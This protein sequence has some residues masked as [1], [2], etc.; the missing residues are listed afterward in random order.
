MA[1]GFEFRGSHGY[2]SPFKE[3][4]N[5]L[6]G[7]FTVDV[8]GVLHIDCLGRTNFV[9][10]LLASTLVPIGVFL[11][12]TGYQFLEDRSSTER[13]SV[14]SLSSSTSPSP[15]HA[16]ISSRRSRASNSTLVMKMA[17][18][19]RTFAQ[20]EFGSNPTTSCRRSIRAS[21]A[22]TQAHVA[23]NAHTHAAYTRAHTRATLTAI[24]HSL[25]QPRDPVYG[26][27]DRWRR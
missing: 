23:H 25:P 11:L 24:Y 17:T 14:T 12:E 2:P 20:S 7:I 4:M 21:H 1:S 5:S 3:V 6:S 16:W 9:H 15:P 18:W 10:K 26:P 19:T 8:V 13:R 22:C 27:L